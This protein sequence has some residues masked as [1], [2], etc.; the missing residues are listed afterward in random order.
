MV[1]IGPLPGAAEWY[2]SHASHLFELLGVTDP[3][4]P[5][6]RLRFETSRRVLQRLR[7]QRDSEEAGGRIMECSRFIDEV[8]DF[9]RG[10]GIGRNEKADFLKHIWEFSVGMAHGYAQW[11]TGQNEPVLA[12]A[13]AMELIRISQS[14]SRD[15]PEIWQA[16]GGAFYGEP[17]SDYPNA[18]GRM[19]ALKNDLIWQRISSFGTPWAPFDQEGSVG[20]KNVRRR[21]AQQLGLIQPKERLQPVPSGSEWWR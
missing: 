9:T 20:T 21:E 15:W 16:S 6:A 3:A 18:P 4:E 7:L 14:T 12:A 13:P 17:E 1:L 5:T 11:K 10:L 8:Y 19:I 2:E